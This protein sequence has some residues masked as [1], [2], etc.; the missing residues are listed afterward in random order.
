[1]KV[2]FLTRDGEL[3]ALW[4]ALKLVIYDGAKEEVNFGL[5]RSSSLNRCDFLVGTSLLEGEKD[6]LNMVADFVVDGKRLVREVELLSFEY[7]EVKV[8]ERT[9]A[10]GICPKGAVACLTSVPGENAV[11]S[12]YPFPFRDS[13]LDKVVFF[14]VLDYDMVREA[15]RVLR[16][17]GEV[18][19]WVRDE[20]YGGVNPSVALKFLIRFHVQGASLRGK[21]WVIKGKKLK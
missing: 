14:E 7:P 5:T 16:K 1:M 2:A 6:V 19:L 10:V 20:V 3:S 21:Y 8:S 4:N 11:R 15:N 17:G 18:E 12:I 9:L 13:S